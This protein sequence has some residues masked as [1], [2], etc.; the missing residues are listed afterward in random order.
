M[1]PTAVMVLLW[2]IPIL[3]ILHLSNPFHL[4]QSNLNRSK[5]DGSFTMANSVLSPCEIFPIDQENKYMY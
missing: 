4:L 5:T 1:P 3:F 2:I